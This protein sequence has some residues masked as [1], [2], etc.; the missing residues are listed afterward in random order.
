MILV[1]GAGG[2]LGS[3]L[4]ARYPKDTFAMT[5][6]DMD[7][8]NQQS[9]E[10]WI[11]SNH[12]D[13]IIN[14]AGIV[15]AQQ[16]PWLSEI[17]RREVT[18]EVNGNAPRH[19]A[20]ICDDYG[21]RMI[22][23]STD[24]VFSGMAGFPYT[25]LHQHNFAEDWYGRS[26]YEGEIGWSP[27]LTIRTSFVGWPDPRKHGL[28]AWL[29]SH[30]EGTVVPGWTNHFW[31][32]LT[33]T[34]LADCLMEATYHRELVGIRHFAGERISKYELLTTVCQVLG[35]SYTIFPVEVNPAKD[36]SLITTYKD[37][38]FVKQ[39]GTFEQQLAIMAEAEKSYHEYWG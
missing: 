9:L 10:K 3:H 33:V 19:I 8:R 22:Q 5:H 4:C 35:W 36:V 17:A 1:L 28:L 12:P 15:K 6:E 2:L 27:H 20:K 13:V 38:P 16:M 11:R 24:C 34:T 14:C 32:G 31:T 18:Q 39:C 30:K 25:E 23:I 29:K 26:K 7:I 21:I 37:I